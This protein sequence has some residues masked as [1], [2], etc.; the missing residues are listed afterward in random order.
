M[1]N[2][3]GQ[4]SITLMPEPTID[5]WIPIFAR[6]VNE[7]L[8]TPISND[9]AIFVAIGKLTLAMLDEKYILPH[10][11]K[12]LWHSF[13]DHLNVEL[14]RIEEVKR[15]IEKGRHVDNEVLDDCIQTL[16]LP[17]YPE[18]WDNLDQL[19]SFVL[20]LTALTMWVSS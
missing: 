2:P 1:H 20:V 12:K 16:A 4:D 19:A 10:E 13:F 9:A 5:D 8:N 6:R 17:L 7:H 14:E 15:A 11:Q 18:Q 3:V